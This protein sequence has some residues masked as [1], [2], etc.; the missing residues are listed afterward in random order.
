MQGAVTVQS[1]FAALVALRDSQRPLSPEHDARWDVID[2]WLRASHR[3]KTTDDE[4]AIQETLLAIA[5]GI[6]GMHAAS[7]REAASWIATIHRHNRITAVRNAQRNA[8]HRLRERAGAEQPPDLDERFAGDGT[9]V[10]RGDLHE[11]F[12]AEIEEA[13]DVYV[14]EAEPNPKFRHL[15]RLQALAAFRKLV[16]E[17]NAETVAAALAEGELPGVDRIYKWVERGRPILLEAIARW[18]EQ[19][20]GWAWPASEIQEAIRARVEPRRVDWGR[21]RPERRKRGDS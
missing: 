20:D 10:L 14:A 15:R 8:A 17:E 9:P 16:L 21:P 13:I 3:P 19:H 12:V 7:P 4:D 11:R 2:A 5:R 1:L 6:R 18:A